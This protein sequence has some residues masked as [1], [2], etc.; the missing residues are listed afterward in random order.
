MTTP[1]KKKMDIQT[2]T[3]L[4]ILGIVTGGLSSIVGVGGGIILVPAL[5]YLIGFNQMSAQGTSLALI[6][7]P[8]GILGVIQY[9]K[10]GYVDFK[11]VAIIALGFI[12]GSLFGSKV[13]LSI[14]QET[15]KKIFAGIMLLMAI[16]MLFFDHKK[17]EP[18]NSDQHQ[19]K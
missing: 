6:M 10:A 7:F 18:S 1:K 16:K 13:A 12:L 3:I 2:I 17:I 4:V 19:S 15:V 11:V 9:Y 5:V 8:V 14:P